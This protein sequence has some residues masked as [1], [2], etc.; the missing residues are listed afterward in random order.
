[1]YEIRCE[2]CGRIGFHLSRT[3]AESRAERHTDETDHD[4]SV[5]V[6]EEALGSG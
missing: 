1:M 2:T 5:V 3:G 4:S 6:Q